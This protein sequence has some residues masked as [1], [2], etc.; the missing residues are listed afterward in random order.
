M[1][2]R[3]ISLLLAVVMTLGL[4]A[5]GGGGG[6]HMTVTIDGN[7]YNLSGDFQDV[8][9]TIVKDDIHVVSTMG[10]FE[11]DENGYFQKYDMAAVREGKAIFAMEQLK[12]GVINDEPVREVVG[13]YYELS[14]GN[15]DYKTADGITNKS[16]AD[17]I[18]ALT[19]YVAQ[20]GIRF[21]GN[22]SYAG[23]YIDGKNVDLTEYED[24]LEKLLADV[25]DGVVA[26]EI[27]SEY[28]Y[29]ISMFADTRFAKSNI[30]MVIFTDLQQATDNDDMSDFNEK[31]PFFEEDMLLA[32]AFMDAGAKLMNDDIKNYTLI[33][34]EYD[35]NDEG[36]A[37]WTYFYDYHR[38]KNYD[39]HKFDKK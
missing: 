28:F 19:G 16:D 12:M 7:K 26:T 39:I 27:M 3:L 34:Y 9:G 31:Y 20:Q 35:E 6:G 14:T 4:T 15:A 25:E 1:K 36:D 5:C 38:D 22:E 18:A 10:Q 33:I 32:L 13:Q 37:M 17:D 21:P 29:G 30:P 11:F 23:F 8:V 2:K 24:E